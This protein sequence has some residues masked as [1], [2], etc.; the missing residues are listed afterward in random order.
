MLRF[1]FIHIYCVINLTIA[2]SDV[3]ELVIPIKSEA[4]RL[5]L[6]ALT[7]TTISEPLI[8]LGY[9]LKNKNDLVC[10]FNPFG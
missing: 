1:K 9:F 3:K 8:I 2:I 7:G 10:F 4:L 6:K 5:S